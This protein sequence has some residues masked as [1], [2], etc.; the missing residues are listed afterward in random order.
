MNFDLKSVGGAFSN[1]CTFLHG[2]GSFFVQQ[3]GNL[4]GRF[5]TVLQTQGGK[6][7]PYLQNPYFGSAALFGISFSLLFTAEKI[8]RLVDVQDGG[9]CKFYAGLGFSLA[10]W[11]SGSLAFWHFAGLSLHAI[12]MACVMGASAIAAYSIKSCGL[13][14]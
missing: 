1:A 4:A 12:E 8:L 14:A 10:L 6:A 9:N 2:C 11:I 7:L 13:I 3:T 5:I